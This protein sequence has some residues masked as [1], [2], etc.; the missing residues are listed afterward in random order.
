MTLRLRVALSFYRFDADFSANP[1]SL[2]CIRQRPEPRVIDQMW[3]PFQLVYSSP[4][5]TYFVYDLA[6]F[7]HLSSSFTTLQK[8]LL[9]TID[10]LAMQFELDSKFDCSDF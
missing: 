6:K 3:A 10:W 4:A 9:P 7:S 2:L 8:I 5:K 1:F